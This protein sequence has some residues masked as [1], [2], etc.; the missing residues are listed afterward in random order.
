MATTQ[1]EY[2]I[3]KKSD[4]QNIADV[5]RN[6][7]GSAD[8]IPVVDLASQ[9]VEAFEAYNSIIFND[10]SFVSGVFIPNGYAANYTVEHNLGRVPQHALIF[11]GAQSVYSRTQPH[12]LFASIYSSPAGDRIACLYGTTTSSNSAYYVVNDNPNITMPSEDANVLS[13]YANAI[14]GATEN[15]ISFGD[16]TGENTLYLMSSRP[17]YWIV[18]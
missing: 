13:Y 15:T 5:V 17:Y 1:E 4:L 2:V 10:T 16:P 12:L 7:S 8:S 11:L 3:V 9:L 18:W 6:I 14:Y